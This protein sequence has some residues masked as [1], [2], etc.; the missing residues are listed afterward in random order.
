[1]SEELDIPPAT[2]GRKFSASAKAFPEILN[3]TAQSLKA[4]EIVRN[5]KGVWLLLPEE[6]AIAF[7]ASIDSRRKASMVAANHRRKLSVQEPTADFHLTVTMLDGS[8][9]SIPC[10]EPMNMLQVAKDVQAKTG[11]SRWMMSLMME[12]SEAPLLIAE[13]TVVDKAMAE[14]QIYLLVVNVTG[15]FE[16][17]VMQMQSS[18]PDDQLDATQAMRK[19][20][21]A[22]KNP[23]IDEALKQGSLPL[24]IGFL[25]H[26]NPATLQFEAAWA[27]T[28]IASGTSEHS[29]AVAEEGGVEEL[30][31]LLRESDNL[32]VKEQCVWALG[33]IA[34]DSTALRNLVLET[35]GAVEAVQAMCA[36]QAGLGGRGSAVR[37]AI[38]T[39]SNFCRGKPRPD[40]ELVRPILDTVRTHT[41]ASVDEEI[42]TDS[43][44]A[45]SYLSDGTN[46]QIQFVIEADVIPRVVELLG[47]ASTSIVTPA[48][49]TVG[50]IVTGDDLQTQRILEEPRLVT[51][52]A[53]L[54]DHAKESIQKE[55][56]WT[57]SNITAGTPEQIQMVLDEL[58]VMPRIVELL[59]SGPVAIQKEAAWAI[60]N[61]TSGGSPEQLEALIQLGC[62]P[63]LVSMASFEEA[64]IQMVALEALENLIRM[65]AG[66]EA[67]HSR[68][69]VFA[70][71]VLGLTA[72]SIESPDEEIGHKAQAFLNRHQDFFGNGAADLRGNGMGGGMGD[73]MDEAADG[74]VADDTLDE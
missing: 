55:A 44:W 1:M 35:D 51:M 41:L 9:C 30:T 39:L 49:R 34:G 45:L 53:G 17:L 62:I 70:E 22:E 2:R 65:F 43:C 56:C 61:V 60:A 24:L 50:N 20:L 46:A 28:N 14:K 15:Q 58:A 59:N 66:N 71:A 31:R 8:D 32:D 4:F 48:L 54:L 69:D 23:P 67:N 18:S 38:W 5:A 72:I 37:N 57:F 36:D 25:K 42:L 19:M 16:G 27:L 64:R 68:A 6:A 13:T 73:G 74:P 47:H 63:H 21:S 33:N 29:Q 7:E 3:K 40:F 26:G 52:L 11:V 12:D 10:F